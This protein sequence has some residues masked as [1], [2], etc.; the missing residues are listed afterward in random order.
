ME[1]AGNSDAATRC[2]RLERDI[3]IFGKDS[4]A[5]L[6]ADRGFIGQD[7]I[8]YLISNAIPFTIRRKEGLCPFGLRP[9]KQAFQLIL[10]CHRKC[11]ATFTG[12]QARL[13]I[14]AKVPKR[15]QSIIVA[16]N[17]ANHDAR[18]TYRKRWAIEA[19]FANAKT[20]GLNCEDTRLTDPAKL[21]LLTAIIALAIAWAVRAART[22]LGCKV[23]LRKNHGYLAKSYFR[24]GFDFIRNRFRSDPQNAVLDQDQWGNE[25]KTKITQSR[26]V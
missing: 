12:L 2:A 16:T 26:V 7:W 20:R 17:R 3:A 8:N 1:R 19:M 14:A 22:K 23:P 25:R 6:L 5:M 4:I 13:N 21:H 24:T 18:N 10:R 15:G 9:R 11:I